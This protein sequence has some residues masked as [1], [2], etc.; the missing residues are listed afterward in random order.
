MDKYLEIPT[1]ETLL[2][3][4]IKH[5]SLGGME[6]YTKY[7]LLEKTFT[8]SELTSALLKNDGMMEE[9]WKVTFDNDMPEDKT[10]IH[11][12]SVCK[13]VNIY[14]GEFSRLLLNSE[15]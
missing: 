13:G 3:L 9:I 7:E 14:L 11:M 6:V 4:K 2:K 15:K 10:D 8:V 12:V 1:E 5:L